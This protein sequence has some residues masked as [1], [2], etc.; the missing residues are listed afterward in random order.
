M[1]NQL[2]SRVNVVPFASRQF[3]S[4]PQ[5]YEVWWE[6][7]RDIF[8]VEIDFTG[9][10]LPDPGSVHLEYWQHSWPEVRV[11]KGEVVG[12]GESGWLANDDWTNGRWQPADCVVQ[13]VGSHWSFLFAPLNHREFPQEV[14]FPARFRRSLKLRVHSQKEG[15]SIGK[16]SAFTDSLWGEADIK[17]EWKSPSAEPCNWGGSL[18]AF[19]GEV[20]QVETLAGEVSLEN[21]KSWR[22]TVAGQTT[23]AVKATIR[24]AV[25][26]DRNSFDRTIVTLRSPAFG[27]SLPGFSFY[28]E[29][30]LGE[31]PVYARDLGVIISRA[32]REISLA[33]YDEEWRRNHMP[34]L[35]ER[36][37]SLPEQTW[38][39]AWANMPPKR[40]RM[41]FVIGCEGAR[42][43][44]RVHPNG[45]VWICE[46]FIRRVPG[47]D[48]PR[49]GWEGH[50]LNFSFGFP[51]VEPGW[52]MILEDYLP[53]IQT[54][55]VDDGVCYE[56]E[57]FADWLFGD[58]LVERMAGD[59]PVVAMLKVTLTNQSSVAKKVKLQIA[60]REDDRAPE[61]LIARDKL[62][63]TENGVLRL[64][65]DSNGT[66]YLS[67]ST[68]GLAYIV[69]LDAGQTH[70]LFIKI[71]HIVLST[72]E[73]LTRLAELDHQTERIRVAQFW[74]ERTAQGTQIVTPNQ[75]I[76]NF[77]RTHL[78]HMLVVNDREPGSDCNVAR[79]GG[80]WYGSFPDE[81]CMVIDDLDRRGYTKEAER[82]LDLYIKY[83]GTTPLPG[84]FQSVEGVFYGG[85]GYEVAGYNRNHGWVLWTLA[86][87]YRYS[88]DRDYLERIAPALVKGC[89]WIIRE[90][91]ATMKP[92]TIQYGFLPSGS[93]EDVTDYWTWLATNAYAY[94]GF[95][96]AAWALA[97]LDHSDA[98]LM[99]AEASAFGADLRK[100]F[101][102]SCARS[103]LVRLRDDRWI[104][105]FPARQE[106]RGRDFGWLR[107]VL[108]G[109][110]HLIYCG[111][112][113]PDE[114]A[115]RWILEDY[116]DNLFLSDQY[117]YPPD[118]FERQ[119]FH[120]GGFSNQSN[121]LLIPPIYLWRDQPKHY[122][123][124]YFNAFTSAFFPD[125][126][127][128]CE[129]AL[130]T[131]DQWRGDHFKTSD[132]A[133]S[134]SWLR[135]MFLNEVGDELWIGQAIPRPW[136]EHGKSMRVERAYTFFGETSLEIVSQAATGW[137]VVRVDPPRRNPPRWMRVRVRHPEEKPIRE[138]WV[139]GLPH[140]NF[141]VQ[142]EE[143]LLESPNTLSEIRVK[144]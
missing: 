51:A 31:E 64:L 20:L 117:G 85:G 23:G 55:W 22:S 54:S 4:T 111:L 1:A 39:D 106:R 131:L 29:D 101:F 134:T 137:I 9:A 62:V 16:I 24:Y 17:I 77:Y 60:A 88:R 141:D 136:F 49:L 128:M 35:Y 124:A 121:L 37:E 118:D 52:R 14:D 50:A 58:M 103:P 75:T 11:A 139:N 27:N 32:D 63:Y 56:Q 86:Q 53:I 13:Q 43:K 48:T 8:Q 82:C 33:L 126:L 87:H 10:N 21:G 7:P 79:C 120:W 93:L 96:A 72:P 84:N 99:Q 19:N 47:K 129:H 25:N 38:E 67:D 40:S 70:S 115:A 110:V 2:Q 102:E 92:G 100:G 83:Q 42:Q 5:D 138:V 119:W 26:E 68:E 65:W 133:N 114:P 76:N 44:F 108:E 59:D 127:T 140:A 74:R 97:E 57:A 112:I 3:W 66:G 105:H 98:A 30:A 15:T 18:Q 95:A 122:L 34:T 36:I 94:W 125:T 81:G 142:K 143:I 89:E 91:Q 116:E 71:P 6:D 109:S 45:D 41:Y 123:R 80:F 46:N 12:A 104:P 144:F 61:K 113:A 69:D 73:E 132:E 90:R 28:V 107:E 130:P 135:F 78:M